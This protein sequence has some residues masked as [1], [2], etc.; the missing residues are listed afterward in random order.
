MTIS[1]KKHIQTAIK[2][3]EILKDIANE[4]KKLKK[5]EPKCS[6]CKPHKVH[7]HDSKHCKKCGDDMTKHGVCTLTSCEL[8]KVEQ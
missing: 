4:V 2:T 3:D 5:K 8:Y 6:I 1:L 7:K